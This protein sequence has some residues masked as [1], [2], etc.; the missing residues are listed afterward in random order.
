LNDSEL[1]QELASWVNACGVPHT[2]TT[3]LLSILQKAGHKQTVKSV[4]MSSKSGMDY[5]NLGASKQL[6]MY[7]AGLPV[8]QQ[9]SLK[10]IKVA[11]NID[12]LQ[13]FKSSNTYMWPILGA[14]M[15]VTPV[16]V[17]PFAVT[18]G[19]SKPSN[20]D[21]LVDVIND[22]KEL[23]QNGLQIDD[24]VLNVYLTNIV[25]DAPARALVKATKL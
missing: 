24:T 12:G 11:L 15:N 23:M 10:E 16:R 8:E 4:A 18:C 21:F 7:V 25:C 20:L 9:M 5:V 22:L 1:Q 13:L 17:L 6:S 2:T 19:G 14:V 3:K